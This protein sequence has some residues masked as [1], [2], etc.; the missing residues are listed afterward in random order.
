MREPRFR[1]GLTMKIGNESETIEF[2]GV[3]VDIWILHHGSLG[4]SD[5]VPCG[6]MSAVGKCVREQS[7]PL[8]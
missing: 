1:L 4:H 6:H 3:W 7:P 2:F 8:D 5:P